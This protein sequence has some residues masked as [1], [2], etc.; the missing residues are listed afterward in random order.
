MGS[1]VLYLVTATELEQ[2]GEGRAWFL[3]SIVGNL[4]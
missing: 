3:L 1:V 2:H 4:I